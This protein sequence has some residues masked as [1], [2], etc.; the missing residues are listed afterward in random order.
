MTR[1]F[2]N[3]YD[4]VVGTHKHKA[5]NFFARPVAEQYTNKQLY[6]R[7]MNIF[8]VGY[9]TSGIRYKSS[10]NYDAVTQEA[11]RLAYSIKY[12]NYPRNMHV[13]TKDGDYLLGHLNMS[14]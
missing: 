9:P 1:D 7:E 4:S 11:G 5:L 14:K 2:Y 12:W 6:E 3:K 13:P 8:T 10:S